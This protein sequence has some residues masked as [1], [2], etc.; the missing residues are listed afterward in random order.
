[1]VKSQQKGKYN[2][3]LFKVTS[4]SGFAK[5]KI[6]CLRGNSQRQAYDPVDIHF[7]GRAVLAPTDI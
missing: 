4:K 2:K 5:R 1:M 7:H 6:K 3:K